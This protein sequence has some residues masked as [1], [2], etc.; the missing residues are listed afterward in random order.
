M[1]A[2]NDCLLCLR[3]EP[4]M[5]QTGLVHFV[6]SVQLRTSA[7]T[8]TTTSNVLEGCVSSMPLCRTLTYPNLCPKTLTVL[9]QDNALQ[10]SLK[11][12]G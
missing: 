3:N 7:M 11:K 9:P 6:V 8:K 2:N 10:L 5:A 1:R 4:G 12:P